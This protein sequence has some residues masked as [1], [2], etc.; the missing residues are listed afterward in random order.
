MHPPSTL[1]LQ[2]PSLYCVMP[3]TVKSS[4]VNLMAIRQSEFDWNPRGQ[5]KNDIQFRE[6]LHLQ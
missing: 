3:E 5:L 6:Y 1:D 2:A 4:R